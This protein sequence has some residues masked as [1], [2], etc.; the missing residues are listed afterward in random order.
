[1]PSLDIRRGG[2][3]GADSAIPGLDINPPNVNVEGG[4]PQY[5]GQR[6]ESNATSQREGLGGWI[7]NLVKRGKDNGEEGS[8]SGSYRRINQDDD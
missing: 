3:L 6:K 5:S 1:M 7:S 8:Q 2:G 4:K